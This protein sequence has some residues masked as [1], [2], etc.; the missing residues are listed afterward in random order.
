MNN[1]VGIMEVIASSRNGK[2]KAIENPHFNTPVVNSRKPKKFGHRLH[3]GNDVNIFE[4]TP[5]DVE[6]VPDEDSP[7][8]VVRKRSRKL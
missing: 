5:E 8:A 1:E 3:D 2:R 7:S 4:Q 6:I